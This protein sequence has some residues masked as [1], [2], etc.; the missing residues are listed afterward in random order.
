MA[1]DAVLHD[2]AAAELVAPHQ[3]GDLE[4]NRV[5]KSAS[6]SA[7]SPP[8]TT[9]ISRSRKKKPSHVAQAL[10]PRPRNASSEGR[11]S[12]RAEA[13]VATIDGIRLVL[14]VPG[15]HPERALG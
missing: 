7:V 13:P 9:A 12:H 15:P 3:H 5:R 11:P 6:S 4:A 10:T 2:L 1:Q 14:V 8:P